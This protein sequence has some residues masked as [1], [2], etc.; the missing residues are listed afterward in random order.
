L[1]LAEDDPRRHVVAIANPISEEMAVMRRSL[2]PGLLR[3]VAVNQ[4]HQRR[5]GGLFEI[6]R[7]YAPRSDGQADEPEQ[8]ACVLF[9]S[10]GASGWRQSP[11]PVDVFSAT[12]VGAALAATARV[13]LSPAVGAE[14]YLHPVRQAKLV[15]GAATIGV[16][17]EV[18]PLVLEAAG[19]DGPVAF[20]SLS[21][22]EILEAQAA[23]PGFEDLISVPVSTRD[24]AVVV[25][26]GVRSVDLVDCAKS[27]GA[28]LVRSAEIFDRYVGEQVPDA[29]V[30]LAIRLTLVEP[31]RT[32]TDE[33]IDAAVGRVVG[34]LADAGATLRE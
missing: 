20:A 18:H 22:A 6:G 4:S 15:A 23:H 10:P 8:I 9:G 5:D 25:S 14:P 30:G 24:V 28:P 29:H 7:T 16:A 33:E 27:A 26:E 21:L 31:G 13:K 1:R 32:L 11:D 12:G 3:A 2:L 34:A 19:V 17:G